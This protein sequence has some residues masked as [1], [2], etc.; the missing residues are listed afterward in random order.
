MTKQVL[1][2]GLR[3]GESGLQESLET[4]VKPILNSMQQLHNIDQTLDELRGGKHKEPKAIVPE[5][6]HEIT[7]EIFAPGT[8]EEV[9]VKHDQAT[10]G[11]L[12]TADNGE[13]QA[14]AAAERF[15][16]LCSIDWLSCFSEKSENVDLHHKMFIIFRDI[17]E[18]R[19]MYMQAFQSSQQLEGEKG[20]KEGEKSRMV[21]DLIR[22]GR[23]WTEFTELL[24]A[25]EAV[26]IGG[27]H[28]LTSR[29][30][31]TTTLNILGTIEEGTT[32]EFERLKRLLRTEFKWLR[33]ICSRLRG[34]LPMIME[35]AALLET[36]RGRALALADHIRRR[37]I[38]AFGK[39]TLLDDIE[40]LASC[41]GA[42]FKITVIISLT[43]EIS[44][45]AVPTTTEMD[46]E[47]DTFLQTYAKTVSESWEL[48][49]AGNVDV[50][51]ARI[52][53]ILRRAKEAFLSSY[54]M[55]L[56][57]HE[58]GSTATERA[59]F[60]RLRLSQ[61]IDDLFVFVLSILVLDEQQRNGIETEHEAN[62]E[63]FRQEVYRCAEL[64]AFAMS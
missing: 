10:T 16:M 9:V 8:L 6:L 5:K 45:N 12:F 23:R 19:L 7:R 15:R 36:D 48:E 27:L 38:E 28:D 24:G 54:D 21:L 64:F 34:V 11:G 17:L 37:C 41:G 20:E 49:I 2:E 51:L 46:D 60:K 55:R 47:R 61:A 40:T 18:S 35:A 44:K 53:Q 25:E 30:P 52:E 26:L 31:P 4:A 29:H 14:T 50:P 33:D 42:M 56:H 22:L 13:K 32:E 57:R 43:F 39:R 3:S 63:H 62:E 1:S 58:K 59:V